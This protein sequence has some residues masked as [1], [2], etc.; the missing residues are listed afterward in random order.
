MRPP[1]NFFLLPIIGLTVCLV[2][3]TYAKAI[4]QIVPNIKTNYVR[5]DETTAVG[6]YT[7]TNMTPQTITN[8]TVDPG[9]QESG[10][11]LNGASVQNNNCGGATLASG[12]SCTFQVLVNGTSLQNVTSL[13]TRV[14]GY[15]SAICS[16]PISSN[17]LQVHVQELVAP[18]SAYLGMYTGGLAGANTVQRVNALTEQLISPTIPGF[19][20][21]NFTQGIAVSPNGATVYIANGYV[22]NVIVYDVATNTII[23]TIGNAEYYQVAANAIPIGVAVSP[24]GSSLY[25]TD[26]QNGSV[27]VFNVTTPQSP[28]FVKSIPT[29]P[30]PNPHGIAVSP[31]GKT[32]YVTDANSSLPQNYG[33]AIDTTNNYALTTFPTG[34]FTIGAT[35]SHD[36]AKLY[37]SSSPGFVYGGSPSGSANDN[38]EIFNTNSLSSEVV[39]PLPNEGPHGVVLSPNDAT[40]YVANYFSDSV[41]IITN[42][43]SS[44]P[45]HT[46]ITVV[47]NISSNPVGVAITPDGLKLYVSLEG[48]SEFGV[49][50][51]SNGISNVIPVAAYQNTMG[52]F[53]G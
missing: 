35:V 21:A 37:F 46:K 15:G 20:F 28:V 6:L 50:N 22:N 2:A 51:L 23:K 49:I 47:G 30:L 29:S 19:E 1:K 5:P 25:T 39:I 43:N 53:V 9:Y 13:M 14:C 17:Y 38:V 24:D 48:L 10:N 7:V 40:L 31:D 8:I 36:G 11:S 27:Y 4:F 42:L 26:Y 18:V 52:H 12:A 34:Q 44:T 45:P 3:P 32:V 33:A 16:K 41:D